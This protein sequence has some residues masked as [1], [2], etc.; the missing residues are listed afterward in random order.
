MTLREET[1]VLSSWFYLTL[2]PYYVGFTF[3]V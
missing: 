1:V 3:L 2:Y